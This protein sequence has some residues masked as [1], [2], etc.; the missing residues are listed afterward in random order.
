MGVDGGSRDRESLFFQHFD[1]THALAS[2]R[3]LDVGAGTQTFADHVGFFIHGVG[4]ARDHLYM[5]L[6]VRTDKVANLHQYIV[7][8]PFFM[9]Q[10]GRVAGYPVDREVTVQ[11][12]DDIQVGSI[13]NQFHGFF[14]FT[15]YASLLT[16]S[17]QNYKIC[18]INV[19]E[20]GS[21][22][23]FKATG[24]DVGVDMRISRDAEREKDRDCVSAEVFGVCL[25]TSAWR[26]PKIARSDSS[27]V[28]GKWRNRI[29][30]Y[31]W[32]NNP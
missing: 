2:Y 17:E 24:R 20:S 25:G 5:Q 14:A 8:I 11:L 29:I 26:D 15:S 31:L 9:G 27:V 22:G 4:I 3:D 13:D 16:Y 6:V 12:L 18:G 19:R 1:D 28:W 23:D 32:K 30:S 21:S 7:G 10:N